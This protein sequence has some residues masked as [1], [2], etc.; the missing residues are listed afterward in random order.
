MQLLLRRALH[1]LVLLVSASVLS[2]VLVDLAPG[3]FFD[4]MRMNPQITPKTIASMRS[5]YGLNRP[6]PIR[7]LRW[8]A[9]AATGDWGVSFAYNSPAGPIVWARAQN[10][11]LLAGS[12]TLMAWLIAIPAGICAAARPGS[13]IDLFIS[14]T[15]ASL[16]AIPELVLAIVLL[17]FAVRTR[18]LPSAGMTS[19]NFSLIDPAAKIRDVLA[20]LVL[21]G[22]CLTAG[23]LPL[24]LAHVRTAVAEVLQSSFVAAAGGYGISF[25][26]ILVCQAL[27]AAANPLISLF[28]VSI[29]LLT[30]SSLIVEVIFS[31]PGLGQLM[32]EAILQRDFFVIVDV[33]LLATAFVILGN[34]IGDLLLYAI[35]PRVRQA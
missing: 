17:L 5:Q 8:V 24:L 12:A 2:F 27:P 29:G 20:H 15:T 10:T 1:S 21:P 33:S 13:W 32:L 9:S 11:L 30:S 22:F 14:G 34:A 26:R 16:M 7:Y 31:W 35:D 23:L 3:D 28:G 4:A 18:C 25:W 6:L 19:V